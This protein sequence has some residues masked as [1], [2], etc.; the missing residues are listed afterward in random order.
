[1]VSYLEFSNR[2]EEMMNKVLLET[3]TLLQVEVGGEC[4]DSTE[5]IWTSRTTSPRT[6]TRTSRWI[7]CDFSDCLLFNCITKKH[8]TFAIATWTTC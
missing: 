5:K 3:D 7:S 4:K 1:M 6:L 8:F 2:N